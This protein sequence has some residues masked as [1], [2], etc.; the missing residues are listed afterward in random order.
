M[1]PLKYIPLG[2]AKYV[3]ESPTNDAG[4]PL[5]GGSGTISWY[6]ITG[7]NTATLLS[8]ISVTWNATLTRYEAAIPDSSTL[9]R[10]DS[11]TWRG[12][13]LIDTT[14]PAA[15]RHRNTIQLRVRNPGLDS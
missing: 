7:A 13:A 5:S 2:P 14:V 9:E 10:S 1:T 11:D 3:L 6:K 8:T 15:T 12:V 4:Q